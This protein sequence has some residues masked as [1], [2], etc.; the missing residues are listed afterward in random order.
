MVREEFAKYDAEI[1]AI[2]GWQ[3]TNTQVAE[4]VTRLDRH[5]DQIGV[6]NQEM[7]KIRQKITHLRNSM[8][9]DT[10]A[11]VV[12]VEASVATT[13]LAQKMRQRHWRPE[14]PRT[15]NRRWVSFRTAWTSYCWLNLHRLDAELRH[16]D[17]T[18]TSFEVAAFFSARCRTPWSHFWC[19]RLARRGRWR[20]CLCLA[21]RG[22]CRRCL[23][24]ARRGRWR[25]LIYWDWVLSEHCQY[26]P[27][28]RVTHRAWYRKLAWDEGRSQLAEE[29]ACLYRV[30]DWCLK[31]VRIQGYRVTLIVTSSL[32]N[33]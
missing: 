14:W 33:K 28:N 16:V 23:C 25:R 22:R 11:R 10:T 19:L 5:R 18:S 24:L 6:L 2:A 1:L 26:I 4:T 30:P 9:E 31:G 12:A 8:I 17:S 3:T 7:P 21:R 15:S 29:V 27:G 13:L 32:N 20:R